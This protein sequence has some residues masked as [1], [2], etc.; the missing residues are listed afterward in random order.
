MQSSYFPEPSGLYHPQYEHDACGVGMVCHIKGK[1]SHDIVLKGITVLERLL[2]RGAAG[3][4]PETGDGAGIMLQL[5][6]VFFLANC[7]EIRFPEEG[8]YG[9]A[10]VFLPT[11]EVQAKMC[12]RTV[13]RCAEEEGFTFLG[14][15]KVPV[16]PGTIGRQARDTAPLIEQFFIA[17]LMEGSSSNDLERR[18]YILRKVIEN[19]VEQEYPGLGDRFYIASLSS[20]TIVY[21]GLFKA[22]QLP[23]FYPDLTDPRLESAAAIV[24]QRYSTNTFPS[25]PLAHPF[26]YIAHNG[27]INTLKGNINQM[28]SREQSLAS[29][30]FGEAV[31]KIHPVI[32][33]GQSDSASLDNVVELLTHS[34][35]SLPHVMMM[36]IPQAWGER[37][38]MGEDVRGFFDFHAGIMEP[39]DGP[40]AIC[41]TNGKGAGAIVDRNGLRPARYALTT[42][43]ML[44]LA[45]EAGVLDLEPSQVVRRGCLHPGQMLW[46]NFQE[47]RISYDAD[48][49]TRVARRQP[50]R[51]WCQEQRIHVHGFFDSVTVPEVDSSTLLQRQQLFSYTQEDMDLIL[52]PMSMTGAEPIGS[53]GND[54][55]LAVLSERP[56]LLFNYFKQL[57]A[58]VT[59]PPIDP[60]REELV[61]SLTTFIG[62]Y[63]NILEENPDMARLIRLARP[64]LTP[65]DLERLKECRER[66]F[67]SATLS[68]T[69]HPEARNGLEHG[70]DELCRQA[71]HK[72]REGFRILILSDRTLNEDCAPIPSLMAVSAVNAYLAGQ[73]LRTRT[74][75]IVDTGEARETMHIALLLGYGATAVCPWLALESVTNL[76]NKGRLGEDLPSTKAIENYISSLDKG[77]LK[78]MSKMG[79]STLRSYRGAQVFEAIGLHRDV[80]ERYFPGTSSR[81]GGIGCEEIQQEVAERYRAAQKTPETLENAG[82]YKYRKGGE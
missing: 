3:S 33:P 7:P 14:W 9:A 50:Y 49:K 5:P 70:I 24:H 65:N 23:R 4:D 42:D 62:N 53:M 56:Q 36:L 35:R 8:K 58:Q 2:H 16:E 15:R 28:K 6:H 54:A 18:L 12:R 27:E 37:H 48:V 79:I 10:C 66:S 1:A 29:P 78:V 44:V 69:F 26:R 43:D 57:F 51:R 67:R 30:L 41:F 61:M 40:S 74:G 68:M 72:I 64:V 76:W 11:D 81:I 71:A 63:P 80:I 60:I 46:I 39:W 25:W 59:N 77:L 20:R 17:P 19:K 34:G 38:F 52:A 45:S 55:A 31:E 32:R 73:G 82:I 75:L 47:G 13:E 22:P 21:K